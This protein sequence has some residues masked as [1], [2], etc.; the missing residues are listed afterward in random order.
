MDE[1]I[2]PKRKSTDFIVIHC[3]ATPEG[4][5]IGAREIDKAHRKQGLNGCGYHTIIRLDGR[6]ESARSGDTVGAHTQGFNANSFAIAYVGGVDA[7]GRAKDTRTEAQ[8]AALRELI[9][10]LHISYPDAKVVGQRDLAT[11]LGR[12]DPFR[13]LKES[14]CFD[15][16]EYA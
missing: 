9:D 3:T 8:K 1:M 13:K 4:Q 12:V 14:P 10:A 2:Y 11:N 5:D 16:S 6:L 15:A 7:E